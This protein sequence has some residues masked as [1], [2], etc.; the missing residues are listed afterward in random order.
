MGED[1]RAVLPCRILRAD[2][3][4]PDGVRPDGL[5]ASPRK[6]APAAAR[7]S[8]LTGVRWPLSPRSHPHATRRTAR[9]PH[10]QRAARSPGR[11]APWSRRPMSAH[12]S[13][14]GLGNW[15]P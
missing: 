10:L 3:L 8:A 4:R 7:A 11:F 6:T 13:V 2:G 14:P 12:R 1:N 5:R 15:I 9:C